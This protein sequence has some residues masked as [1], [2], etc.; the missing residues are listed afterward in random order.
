MTGPEESGPGGRGRK[1]RKWRWLALLLLVIVALIFDLTRAP[2]RQLAARGFLF[3]VD[4]YQ[5]TLSRAMPSL[6]VNCRFHPT[7][8]QYTE[9]AVRNCGL[10]EGLRFGAW[11]ILRCGP[12][13]EAGTDEPPPVCP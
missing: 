12:W 3:A 2:E 8:S 11:R 4:V 13:T 5:A 7:C 10:A 6:G 1:S 9:Q